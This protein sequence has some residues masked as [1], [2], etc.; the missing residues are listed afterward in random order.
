VRELGDIEITV[1]IKPH[2]G[3]GFIKTLWVFEEEGEYS[4]VLREQK[5][6]A[7]TASSKDNVIDDDCELIEQ[8]DLEVNPSEIMAMLGKIRHGLLDDFEFRM[9]GGSFFGVRIERDYQKTTFEWHGD[10][11]TYDPSVVK[12]Y[13]YIFNL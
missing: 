9:L 7:R 5:D 11:E 6:Q 2:H 13:E 8:S 10:M 4:F 3:F 1:W 12:L